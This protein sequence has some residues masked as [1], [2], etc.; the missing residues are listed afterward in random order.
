MPV[1]PSRFPPSLPAALPSRCSVHIC[2][3]WFI[4]WHLIFF[5]R[6]EFLSF[7]SAVGGWILSC[8]PALGLW[9]FW[10]RLQ[11]AAP[12]PLLSLP[13]RP[14][15]EDSTPHLCLIPSLPSL[16]PSEQRQEWAST[17]FFHS[18]SNCLS[19]YSANFPNKQIKPRH[20]K[21]NFSLGLDILLKL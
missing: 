9:A 4:F 6:Y 14:G 19:A 16:L 17:A 2:W 13:R 21:M 5:L 12:R 15:S 3:E 8:K 10:H 18:S 11:P 7:P 20:V 1:W